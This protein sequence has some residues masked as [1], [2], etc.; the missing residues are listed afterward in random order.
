MIY[1][2]VAAELWNLWALQ[3]K[4]PDA[5]TGTGCETAALVC[6]EWRLKVG[7]QGE[8]M[9]KKIKY[10]DLVYSTGKR[11]KKII[12]GDHQ[13]STFLTN[14]SK[15]LQSFVWLLYFNEKK[16]KF[17]KYIFLGRKTPIPQSSKICHCFGCLAQSFSQSFPFITVA[18]NHNTWINSGWR[19]CCISL[20]LLAAKWCKTS[21]NYNFPISPKTSHF[22]W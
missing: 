17:N 10:W 2:C 4:R 3:L 8:L 16:F 6:S 13:T 11:Q 15:F 5:T 14:F 9:V 22:K 18:L 20:S 19:L 12:R 21:Q 1:G 7:Q